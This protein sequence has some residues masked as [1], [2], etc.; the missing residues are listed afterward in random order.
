MKQINFILEL[1][2]NPKGTA[3]MIRHTSH[4]TYLPKNLKQTVEMYKAALDPYGGEFL[5]G[6]LALS[7]TWVYQVKDRKKWDTRKT[8]VP[9]LDN[10][11]KPFIDCMTRKGFWM[12]DSQIVKL[13]LEKWYGSSPLVI[14]E[15]TE[16]EN[17]E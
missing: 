15:L 3:Q 4:G 1:P 17:E 10:I 5:T 14:V 2:E 13:K 16:M 9:D 12:D 8:S 7:V 6:P 11:A